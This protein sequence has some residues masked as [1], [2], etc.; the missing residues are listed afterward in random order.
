M[1]A[2]G[3]C[4]QALRHCP[5]CPRS[6]GVVY[7]QHATL[8]RIESVSG[9]SVSGPSVKSMDPILE[10]GIVPPL[11]HPPFPTSLV[12]LTQASNTT[13]TPQ[14]SRTAGEVPPRM[15]PPPCPPTLPT[16]QALPIT[17]ESLKFDNDQS[18][19]YFEEFRDYGGG[20]KYLVAKSFYRGERKAEDLKED[21]VE[22]C[23][24]LTFTVSER[25]LNIF[26]IWEIKAIFWTISVKQ[27]F[28]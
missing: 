3:N 21:N 8:P 27:G 18:R 9:P 14:P 16:V 19:K 10:Y 15:T 24:Q 17:E 23:L 20:G 5:E 13:T 1:D 6:E 26:R 7:M 12:L 22:I 4:P 28:F 2:F 25:L 11:P